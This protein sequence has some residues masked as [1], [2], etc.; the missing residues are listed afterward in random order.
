MSVVSLPLLRF[1]CST[2]H[3]IY[4]TKLLLIKLGLFLPTSQKKSPEN[5]LFL[6]FSPHIFYSQHRQRVP[7]E[8]PRQLTF[9]SYFTLTLHLTVDDF[10]FL[11]TLVLYW[12]LIILLILLFGL[13]SIPSPRR[14][15]LQVNIFL[16]LF[17]NYGFSLKL[18]ATQTLLSPDEITHFQGFNYHL[19]DDDS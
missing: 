9:Y 7:R 13:W 2:L 15:L 8:K 11:E 1:G 5:S 12:R 17:S 19:C 18:Y 16:C 14:N 3:Y 10:L 6:I 4:L